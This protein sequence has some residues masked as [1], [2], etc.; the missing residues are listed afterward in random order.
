MSSEQ[1]SFEGRR[2]VVAGGGV[3]ALEAVLALRALAGSIPSIEL[4]APVEEFTQRAS[5]VATP[6]GFGPPAA[7]I[8][9]DF[10][11]RQGIGR[12]GGTLAGVDTRRG[13]AGAGTDARW[14]TTT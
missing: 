13:V 10:A 4:I 1:R 12:I 11:A 7:V 9:E 6:F 8:L 5:S 2:V 3:A 14:Q